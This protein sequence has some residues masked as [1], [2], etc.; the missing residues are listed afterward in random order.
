MHDAEDPRIRDLLSCEQGTRFVVSL[1]S[2]VERDG[3]GERSYRQERE[4]VPRRDEWGH[5]RRSTGV[6]RV[7]CR[8]IAGCVEEQQEPGDARQQRP[9]QHEQTDS[10]L[11][12][13]DADDNVVS[14]PSLQ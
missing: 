9:S 3:H 13:D 11:L 1:P 8:V 7:E 10:Q 4:P 6:A 2:P 14:R 12:V 5:Y